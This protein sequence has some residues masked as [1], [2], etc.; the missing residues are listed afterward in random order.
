MQLKAR[1][2]YIDPVAKT[3]GLTLNPQLL[4]NVVPAMV[5][6]LTIGTLFKFLFSLIFFCYLGEFEGIT[7]CRNILY[8]A[9]YYLYLTVQFINLSNDILLLFLLQEMDVGNV[10]KDAVVRRVDATV[11]MLLELPTKETPAAGYVHVSISFEYFRFLLWNMSTIERS[12][13]WNRGRYLQ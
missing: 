5:L 10:F 7:K 11:G 9:V 12:L 4:N 2:L 3:I 13:C 6:L 8:C 1:I